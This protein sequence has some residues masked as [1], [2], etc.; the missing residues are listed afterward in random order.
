MSTKSY[1]K[2]CIKDMS[3]YISHL[4]L[5]IITLRQSINQAIIEVASEVRCWLKICFKKFKQDP[6]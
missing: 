3:I 4:Y 1:P 2:F 6:S 5:N